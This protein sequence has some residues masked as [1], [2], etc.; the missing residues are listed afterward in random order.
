MIVNTEVSHDAEYIGDIQENRVGIDKENV[1]FI[2]TLLTSNLYSMPL[3]SFFRE[4]VSNA[5]DSHMEAGTNDPVL[6]LIQD[7]KTYRHYRISIRDYGTGLSPERFDTIYRNIGSS[8]KR[9]SNDYIGMFGIGRFSCLSCADT[10]N[11]TSYY[12]GTKYSYIMYKNGGGINIDKVGEIQGDFKNGLEVS[13]EK[14]IYDTSSLRRAIY[15]LCLFKHLHVVYKGEDYMIK[16]MIEEF[17]SRIIK[18]YKTFSICSVSPN[19]KY[20]SIS[21]FKVGNVL[22]TKDTGYLDTY[23]IFINLPMGSVD[24]TPNREALQYT[25]T[26]E[27]VIAQQIEKVKEELA[28]IVK[29]TINKKDHTIASLFREAVGGRWYDI[30]AFPDS[31]LRLSIGKKDCDIDSNNITVDGELVPPEYLKYLEILGGFCFDKSLVHKI[32]NKSPYR[33]EREPSFQHILDGNI[34]L[35]VKTDKV[36]KQV[37]FEH[38]KDSV[39]D[40]AIILVYEGKEKLKEYINKLIHSHWKAN[41]IPDIEKCTDFTLKHLSITDVSNDSV[42]AQY[43]DNYKQETKQKRATKRT[44]EIP[45]RIYNSL[46]YNMGGLWQVKKS[47]GLV[48]YSQHTKDDTVLK[49]LSDICGG[50]VQAVISLKQEYFD[51]IKADRQFV[52]IDTFM[53]IKHPFLVKFATGLKIQPTLPDTLLGGGN[54]PIVKEFYKKYKRFYGRLNSTINSILN[55][56]E[57][58][59]WLNY[60]DIKYYTL[61]EQEIEAYNLWEKLIDNRYK[62]I[63]M[64]VYKKYGRMGKIGLVPCITHKK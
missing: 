21:T 31:E 10:A 6:I 30:P 37:T 17:N 52:H 14:T 3:D 61:N 58:K 62:V 60:Y 32:I 38:F 46:G 57:S 43:I 33:G 8:T 63:Q 7:T 49:E 5:Y 64:L 54:L 1:D 4:T 19:F 41:D 25:S 42:P 44:E 36:T 11:I 59:G 15:A 23:G 47:S 12:N 51:L 40:R 39:K 55:Y 22:Y 45:I 53:Y 56:Y 9:Q 35:A 50:S 20:F 18:D 13:I 26:T 48:I 29:E 34:K 2:T 27:R 28:E 16:N 24:I